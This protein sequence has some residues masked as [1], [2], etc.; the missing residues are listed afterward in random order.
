MD[1]HSQ[2]WVETVRLPKPFCQGHPGEFTEYTWHDLILQAPIRVAKQ[3]PRRFGV[4]RPQG[5]SPSRAWG[6]D[7][8]LE[9]SHREAGHVLIWSCF[10]LLENDRLT[11][12]KKKL[13][14]SQIPWKMTKTLFKTWFKPWLNKN[15]ST[16]LKLMIKKQSHQVVRHMS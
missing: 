1:E 8:N 7:G 6:S 10:E 2:C 5:S 12:D 16:Y 11:H 9:P 15:V 3:G 13:M 4:L 14:L